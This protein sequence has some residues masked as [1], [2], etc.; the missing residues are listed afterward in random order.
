WTVLEVTNLEYQDGIVYAADAFNQEN[1]GFPI[2]ESF[3]GGV[4]WQESAEVENIELKSPPLR[5]CGQLNPGIC[6]RLTSIGIL[7]ELGPERK[8]KN[9]EGVD[10]R[11]TDMIIFDWNDKEYVIVAIGEYGIMRRELPGGEW[12]VIHVLQ[13]DEPIEDQ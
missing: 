3:D 11:C 1:T 12:E 4:T 8:W 5:D 6:Y 9:V 7:Q 10:P 2:A 13:A